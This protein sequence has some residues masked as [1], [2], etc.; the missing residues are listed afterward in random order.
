MGTQDKAAGLGVRPCPA[1]ENGEVAMKY[2]SIA[3]ALISGLCA[4]AAAIGAPAGDGIR[5]THV[6]A[7]NN[8]AL[9]RG[10]LVA[11][12][13]AHVVLA[14]GDF[15]RLSLARDRI[16]AIRVEEAVIALS[17]PRAAA[18]AEAAP[19][20]PE[21]SAPPASS[22]EE[23]APC[24]APPPVPEELRETIEYWLYHLGRTSHK[25]RIQAERH[26]KALG[27]AVVGPVLPY[28]RR[29]EW[30]IR[31]NALRIIAETRHPSGVQALWQALADDERNV[32]LVAYEGLLKATDLDV[33]F[34]PDGTV[35]SRHYWVERWRTA[36]TEAGLL[37]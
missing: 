13:S 26:L 21:P 24:L 22:V 11:E 4:G 19:L 1:A 8:G 18:P 3:I 35:R 34:N 7:L 31:C 23:A 2:G 17:A 14:I 16:A 5:T 6:V 37:P 29:P 30:L 10:T 12:D 28:T 15:G 32:R 36:L 27:P 33:H 25:Y 20:A 9:I